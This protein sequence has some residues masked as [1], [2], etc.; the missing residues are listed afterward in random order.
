[1]FRS[2]K[3][4][5]VGRRSLAAAASALIEQL[6][7][8]S[9][10]SASPI[11]AS[12]PTPSV[13]QGQI[14]QADFTAGQAVGGWTVNWG[15]GSS[16]QFGTNRSH[17]THLYSNTGTYAAT[18]TAAGI[19]ATPAAVAY[20]INNVP[21]DVALTDVP[22]GGFEGTAIS[23]GSSV[24]D[25]GAASGRI[26]GWTVY[27]DG[28]HFILPGN[29]DITGH[30]LKFTPDDNGNYVARLTVLDGQGG[31]TTVKSTPIVVADVAPAGFIGGVPRD[32]VDDGRTVFLGAHATDAGS[33]DTLT[34]AWTLTIDGTP[35][36]LTDPTTIGQTLVAPA[37]GAY[38]ATC[39]VTDDNGAS[40][41]LAPATFT[42]R[43][44]LPTTS[45][46]I[47]GLPPAGDQGVAVNAYATV[48][49]PDDAG[50]DTYVWSVTKDGHA[51]A[52]PDGTN[53]T[54][55]TFSFTPTD[56][57]TY[58]IGVAV[59]DGSNLVAKATQTMVVRSGPPTATIDGAPQSTDEGSAISLSANVTNPD[60]ADTFAWTVTKNGRA[61]A[62]ASGADV[63]DSTFTFVPNDNGG[64]VATVTVTDPAG[65]STT[66]STDN[67]TVVNVAP[68]GRIVGETSANEGDTVS[69][70]A[71]GTDVGT[72]D[73]LT[74]AWHVTRD[75]QPVT[76]PATT[77]AE[78]D[79][80]P[81]TP[82]DY[83]FTATISDGDGGVTDVAQ[84][85]AVADVAPFAA[86]TSPPAFAGQGETLTYTSSV[87]DPGDA[88]QTYAWTVTRD[89][90][91]YALPDGVATNT[92]A[93]SFAA[94]DSGSYVASLTVSDSVG[95]TAVA[96]SNTTIVVGLT[97]S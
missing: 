45:V 7:L 27:R 17:A 28:K 54:E 24:A 65:Q 16:S 3:S 33:A 51:V 15:D 50:S 38:V 43:K 6:E 78:I 23:L 22:A 79:F 62:M 49:G 52:L 80:A 85:V 93:L 75:G 91:N 70:L 71:I 82:G 60:P 56:S 4:I 8:R 30:D 9:L 58:V 47:A 44:A 35:V 32:I 64:Y 36:A 53:T 66:A 37:D 87:I 11:A 90:S 1:M 18:F 92:P 5:P 31:S 40:T 39:I 57:G 19:G 67:I 2:S 14:V 20:T 97:A 72:A 63:S 48:L 61:Y 86:I 94:N 55:S 26:Y 29:T 73:Q 84:A 96:V 34:Y 13:D 69:L 81:M 12:T 88:T 59:S 74:Y 83:V 42:V 76:I 77:T 95:G 41:T 25:A 10:L 21:P 68:V 46:S 89:G